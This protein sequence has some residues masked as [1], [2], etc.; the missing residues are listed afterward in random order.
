MINSV[1]YSI[2]ISLA[3]RMSVITVFIVIIKAVFKT[4]LSAKM[5]CVIWMLMIVQL[6]F[7]ITSISIPTKTSIYN[8]VHLTQLDT[9]QMVSEAVKSSNVKNI[10]AFLW[11][12]GGGALALWYTG[13]HLFYKRKVNKYMIINNEGTIRAL[14]D[15]KKM[16]DIDDYIE[17]R[18]GNTAQMLDKTII[19][20]DG[21]SA[22]EMKQIMLHELCHYKNRDSLKLWTA[23]MVVCFNWFNPLVWY[24]FKVFRTD[25]EMMCDDSV[26]KITDSKKEYA[27][28]LVKTAAQRNHFIPGAASVHNG[29]NEVIRR[30]KRI[31]YWERKKP[32]WMIAA[33]C[34]CVTVSC[35]CLTDAVSVAVE[36]SVEEI[37]STPKPEPVSEIVEHLT[38]NPSPTPTAEEQPQAET[39]TDFAVTE[40][41]TETSVS[42][43]NSGSTDYQSQQD[44]IYDQHQSEPANSGY[45]EEKINNEQQ[46]N[47]EE[48]NTAESEQNENSDPDVEIGS[49]RDD[50]YSQLGDPES[51]SG[52][53]SKET[54]QLD[55]GRTA[56]LQYDG[57]TLES[58]YIINGDE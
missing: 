8:V 27:R 30:V 48:V 10:I 56:V 18:R 36:N 28:V 23:M 44:Y 15:A 40:K 31:V 3:L 32:L 46:S 52:N 37:T 45:A 42:Y 12:V 57:D 21:Y 47:D 16:L 24:A 51:V 33:I 53:G 50:V 9:V 22:D 7:C 5:H 34:V 29:A 6:L 11:I 38:E 54:Y 25:I 13:V 19:L 20:P 2:F 4:K 49:Q 35:I 17:L 41:E 1:L 14:A 43:E 55:D 39:Q 26:L 58:G